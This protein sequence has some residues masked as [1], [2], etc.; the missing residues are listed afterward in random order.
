LV[1][2]CHNP[3]PQLDQSFYILHHQPL[4]VQR[5]AVTKG[6]G[7]NGKV[8]LKHTDDITDFTRGAG[9]I[10]YLIDSSK[11]TR[12]NFRVN[13]QRLT[14]MSGEAMRGKEAHHILPQE[15][16]HEFHAVYGINIHDP[17]YGGFS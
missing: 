6:P 9:E 7:A 16:K 5:R 3:T 15:F 10:E 8:V 12:N 17:K 14:G 13:L 2:F 11:Y 1:G 4:F